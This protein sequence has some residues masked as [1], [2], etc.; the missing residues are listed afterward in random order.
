MHISSSSYK[1]ICA[2]VGV[3]LQPAHTHCVEP[4]AHAHQQQQ[5]L[6]WARYKSGHGSAAT[7]ACRIWDTCTSAAATM[8]HQCKNARASAASPYATCKTW[9]TCTSAAATM[10]VEVR[11]RVLLQPAH[12]QCVEPGAHAHQQ[13]Q[14]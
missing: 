14:L 9:N 12:T 5:T 8:M 2:K 3:V 1:Y 7:H 10:N 4:R 6:F 11:M 13:Q